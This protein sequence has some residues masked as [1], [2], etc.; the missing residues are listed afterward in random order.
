MTITRSSNATALHAAVVTL[1]DKHR[2]TLGFMPREAFL[3][4]LSKGRVLI[5]HEGRDVLG[6]LLFRHVAVRHTVSIT[7]L[8]VDKSKVGRGVARALVDRLVADHPHAHAVEL[9]CRR[10]YDASKVWPRLGFA[11]V[12]ERAGRSTTGELLVDWRRSLG[13]PSLLHLVQDEERGD[14][15]LAAVDLNI[16]LD[17][18]DQR[19]YPESHGLL[20]DWLTECV[21]LKTTAETLTEIDR[22][23]D[24]DRRE[25][26]RR[27]AREHLLPE[28]DSGL[29]AAVVGR[30][31]A[32]LGPA[33]TEQD[34][35]DR[36]QLAFAHLGGARFFVTRDED[37]AGSRDALAEVFDMS[38]VSPVDLIERM[39]LDKD[40][41]HAD[42]SV[43]SGHVRVRR[44]VRTDVEEVARLG[45]PG[46]ETE[47][48]RRAAVSAAAAAP[49]TSWFQVAVAN[50]RVAAAVIVLPPDSGARAGLWAFS[51]PGKAN[52]AQMSELM[53]QA[54]LHA[55]R[56]KIALLTAADGGMSDAA[57]ATAARLGFVRTVDGALRKALLPRFLTSAQVVAAVPD[58][59]F[60]DATD[61]AWPSLVQDHTRP[62]LVVP[63]QPAFAERLLG[64]GR[65][66]TLFHDEL[67][68]M[69]ENAYYRSATGKPPA[70]GTLVLWYVSADGGRAKPG[71][72]AMSTVVNARVGDASE[73]YRDN[74]Q[75]G[76]FRWKEIVD[77]AGPSGK[78]TAIRF[79]RTLHLGRPVPLERLRAL[80][81]AHKTPWQNMITA[82]PIPWALTVALVKEAEP[83]GEDEPRAPGAQAAVC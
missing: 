39:L 57:E 48:R 24:A 59:R 31:D 8:C 51:R 30:L 66:A 47:Q 54:V 3:D 2:A 69:F 20:A 44:G 36:R 70:P 61:V 29:V 82:R 42:P 63:I 35:S 78:V 6:Y 25:L 52:E 73:L 64:W 56:A 49:I 19:P 1:G 79:C 68:F 71:I 67:P 14:R 60:A 21:Q 37:L 34:R 28:I 50:G 76:V 23:P 53:L 74:R 11:P 33:R 40:P 80:Y 55:Q 72:V 41:R 22:H 5:A 58:A 17:W 26:L 62:T 16:L 13:H 46:Q 12:G 45:N 43:V 81:P 32:A 77:V 27:R 15:H 7:H 4:L 38:V 65:P 83:D 75:F 18:V 9:R 10:D